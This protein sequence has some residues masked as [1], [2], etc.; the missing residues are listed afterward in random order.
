MKMITRGLTEHV[1]PTRCTQNPWIFNILMRNI[2]A[3]VVIKSL[4]SRLMVSRFLIL[5][6]LFLFCCG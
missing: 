3:V 1:A 6:G 4:L 2:A 5:P